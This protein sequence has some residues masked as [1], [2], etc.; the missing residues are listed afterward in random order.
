MK[1]LMLLWKEVADQYATWCCT[2]A[3]RDY[4]EV[5][6][7]VK[8]EGI[9]F[10]TITL[11]NLCKDFEKALADDQVTPSLFVGWRKRGNLPLFLGGF[12]ELIF[13][14]E[15]A[16]LRED[17]NVEAIRA[18][19]QL[20]L[21][22]SKILLPT[23]EERTRRAYD[24]YVSTEKEVKHFDQSSR[25]L[26]DFRRVSRLL[27]GPLLCELDIFIRDHKLVPKHGPGKTADKLAG[28]SKFCQASW[29]SRLEKEFPYGEFCIPNWRF[30]Y[31]L[32]EVTSLDPG[33]EVPVRVT[34]VPKTLKTPRIIAIEPTAMQYAQQAVSRD[35][36]RL[37]EQNERVR[38]M[39]GFR[40]A[41]VNRLMAELGSTDG[42]YATLDL[43]EAS[44]RVSNQLVRAIFGIG[45]TSHAIQA[46]R[47]QTADV[48]GYGEIRLSKFASMGSALTF[49]IEAMV[50]L[51]IIFLSIERLEKQQLTM[52]IVN[53]YRDSV[54]VF[55]DDIIV[56]NDV[57]TTLKTE[58][59]S[60]GFVVNTAKS[61]WTGMFR[62]SCGA[63]YFAGEDVTVARVRRVFPKSRRDAQ[64]ILSAVSLRN[65]L[66]E[67]GLWRAVRWLDERIE[68]LIR[69]FPNVQSESPVVGRFSFLG[70]DTQKMCS[71]LHRPLVKGFVEHSPSPA[72]QLDGEFALL[73]YLL[74][75]GDDP[76]SVDH[77]ERQGR[78]DAVY[79]KLRWAPPY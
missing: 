8:D 68:K 26:A 79:L 78:P 13:D 22:Y 54:R 27:F 4:E 19:R 20:T 45:Y 40:D 41:E 25:N 35:L 55:G 1:S 3:S 46:C 14:P 32:D 43:S 38:G 9:S 17:C 12:F 28:N 21:M 75:T 60:Y 59:E 50:F 64:E 69:Y 23:S 62:E 47:S 74:K 33:S 71:D 39:I 61:F 56:P 5:E 7:R 77:L 52:A 72:S 42:S 76:Y 11:P 51:T 66:Y 37:L 29:P 49:P 44:D 57:A 16:V 15:T 53:R 34:A 31:L 10:L 30:N 2:S 65:Q 58:L 24:T 36:T 6:R 70:Y 63:E 73:K 18:V 67:R 48:P